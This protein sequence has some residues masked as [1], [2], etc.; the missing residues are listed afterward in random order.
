MQGN[1]IAYKSP[2]I[3]S[4]V[5]THPP[6]AKV[7]ITETEAEKADRPVRVLRGDTSLWPTQRRLGVTSGG[8]KILLDPE[9]GTIQ[10]AHLLGVHA[11][12]TINIFALSMGA[13]IPFDRIKHFPFTYPTA[14]SDL[15]AME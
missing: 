7:G 3:P 11:E 12:E 6:L 14:A 4:V 1:Q 8:Y 13:G 5:F 10:G 2:V 9:K 15:N